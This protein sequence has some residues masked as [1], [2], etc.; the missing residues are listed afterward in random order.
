MNGNAKL[1]RSRG[2]DL[3]IIISIHFLNHILHYTL[4]TMLIFMKDDISLSY[5]ECGLLWTT[6]IIAMT[7]FS[8]FAGVFADARRRHRFL[9]IWIGLV[10]MILAWWL[11]GV[12][13]DLGGLLVI[14]GLM[15]FGASAFHPPALALI[16]EMYEENKGQA[17]SANI[18]CGM[19]GTAISPLIVLVVVELAGGW[20]DAAFVYAVCISIAAL[21]ILAVGMSKGTFLLNDYVDTPLETDSSN[22][23]PAVDG[24][25]DTN[26]TGNSIKRGN[27]LDLAL[28]FSPMIL[29]PLLLISLRGGFFRNATFFTPILFEDLMDLSKTDASIATA[30]V[31]GFGALFNI[32]G[33]RIADRRSPRLALLISAVAST[34]SVLILLFLLDSG[35]LILF[36]LFYF[37]LMA[38]HYIGSPAS[39]SLLADRVPKEKRGAIFGAV[40]SLGQLIPIATPTLFGWL[41]DTKGEHWGFGLML[42]LAF[43]SLVVAYHMYRIGDFGEDRH[44]RKAGLHH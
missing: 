19:I 8:G 5:T 32:V 3:G 14:Y 31:L 36:T 10:V 2:F 13:D 23:A 6:L 4:P 42:L 24:S 29:V 21:L 11:V 44:N 41:C 22:D 27:G 17:L 12:V 39:S 25:T 1:G 16:T 28:I 35:G 9:L 26:E 7:V 38:S 20:R 18:A 43:L 37:A 34:L 30:V 33:G 15:G 40:F